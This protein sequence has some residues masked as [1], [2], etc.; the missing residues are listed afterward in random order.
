MFFKV[1]TVVS[2]LLQIYMAAADFEKS[3]CA[4]NFVPAQLVH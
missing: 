3:I 1:S 4:I 2:V